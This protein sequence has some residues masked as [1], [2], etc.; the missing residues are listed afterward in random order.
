MKGSR[1]VLSSNLG[2]IRA[3]KRPPIKEKAEAVTN[4]EQTPIAKI[5]RMRKVKTREDASNNKIK[6]IIISLI[7]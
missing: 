6:G 5:G 3:K 1:G 4:R 7:G 2:L